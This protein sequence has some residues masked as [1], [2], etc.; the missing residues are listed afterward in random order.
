M[1]VSVEETEEAVVEVSVVAV[2]EAVI[3]TVSSV[4]SQAT[5]L[6][7]VPREAVVVSAEGAEVEEALEVVVVVEEDSVSTFLN[8]LFVG[9]ILHFFKSTHQL[10][11][12]SI[13]AYLP[14]IFSPLRTDDVSFLIHFANFNIIKKLQYL[15]YQI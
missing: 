9:N 14:V 2:A 15:L 13:L 7:N 5:F 4:K 11:V 10:L 3:T 1:A 6:V 8:A 12:Q